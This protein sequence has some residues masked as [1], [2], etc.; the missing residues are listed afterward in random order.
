MMIG[1]N[2][3]IPWSRIVEERKG[4]FIFS[5]DLLSNYDFIDVIEFIPIL[6][7]LEYVSV[8]GFKFRSSWDGHIQCLS[9]I[10]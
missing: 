4:N 3:N 9:C 10:E 8:E 5:S 1:S 6:I 7:F 2:C